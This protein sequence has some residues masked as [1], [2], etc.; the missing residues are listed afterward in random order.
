M[1]KIILIMSFVFVCF[2]SQVQAQF[3]VIDPANITTSIVN[4][5]N[6]I[7]QTSSTATNMINNFREVQKLYNQ[8]KGYYDQLKCNFFS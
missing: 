3:A 1:K 6:Q 5:A 8:T 4:A 2:T 7:V